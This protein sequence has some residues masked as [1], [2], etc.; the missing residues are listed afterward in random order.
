ML[1]NPFHQEI[2]PDVQPAAPLEAVFIMQHA[3][4]LKQEEKT[5]HK[6]QSTQSERALCLVA[7]QNN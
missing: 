3:M 4:K 7:H 1:A 2:P 6:Y 5:A